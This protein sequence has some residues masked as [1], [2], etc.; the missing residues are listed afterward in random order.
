MR[1]GEDGRILPVTMT[2]EWEYKDGKVN[3]IK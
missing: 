2:T 3:V 1:F